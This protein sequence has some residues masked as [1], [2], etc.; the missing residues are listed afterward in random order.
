[1]KRYFLPYLLLFLAACSKNS[2]KDK[3]YDA[4]VLVL[5]TPTNNQQFVAGQNMIVSGT[6][7]DNKFIDQV[8]IV[9]TNFTTG[10]EYL[11]VHIHPNGNLSN[12][13]QSF[14]VQAGIIYKIQV[15]VDDG[16]SNS[17]AASVNVSCN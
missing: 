3:D 6:A 10:T 8:H 5:N 2:D 14:A 7:T 9:I 11:H 17:T 15:I 4:P 12:F 1:M 16:S 13:S